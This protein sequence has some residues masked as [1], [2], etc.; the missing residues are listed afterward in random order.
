M[1]ARTLALALHEAFDGPAEK[2][3]PESGELMLP[4]A[5]E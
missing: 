1:K 5:A 3:E 2:I 4:M